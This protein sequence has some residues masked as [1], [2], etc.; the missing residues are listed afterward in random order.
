MARDVA[1]RK[2][3]EEALPHVS[4]QLGSAPKLSRN[5]RRW[6]IGTD[7]LEKEMSRPFLV[8]QLTKRLKGFKYPYRQG[9]KR[10]TTF[11][12]YLKKLG[13]LKWLFSSSFIWIVRL[14]WSRILNDQR[15]RERDTRK[16]SIDGYKMASHRALMNEIARH[17]TRVS[18]ILQGNEVPDEYL[19]EYRKSSLRELRRQAETYYQDALL[20]SFIVPSRVRGRYSTAGLQMAVLDEIQ[21]AFDRRN[22]TN[23]T[24]AYQLT[25]LICSPQECISSQKLSPNPEA[26]RT[27]DRARKQKPTRR[28][29]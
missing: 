15:G 25:A 17:L 24:L 11:Y 3:L 9:T 22:L 10:G 14:T 13:L 16:V 12:D 20:F 5:E 21:K 4:E 19:S 29:R 26:V 7:R 1:L 28:H 6:G 27:N 8:E 18:N 23:R 2:L